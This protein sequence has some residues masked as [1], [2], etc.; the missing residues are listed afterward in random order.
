MASR[1]RP[2]ASRPSEPPAKQEAPQDAAERTVIT[3]IPVFEDEMPTPVPRVQTP[4]PRA[5]SPR[6]Q[7]TRSRPD[8]QRRGLNVTPARPRPPSK[9]GAAVP[10]ATRKPAEGNANSM[11][12]E[13]T[14][15]GLPVGLGAGPAPKPKA[16][17]PLPPAPK[18]SPQRSASPAVPSRGP[19]VPPLSLGR[20]AAVP[21]TPSPGLRLPKPG[22]MGSP[23]PAP[24]VGAAP[25]PPSLS[26]AL[27]QPAGLP[28]SAGNAGLPRPT[29]SVDDNSASSQRMM[30]AAGAVV[31]LTIGV[32]V[33]A[34]SDSE[35]EPAPGAPVV[36]SRTT[37]TPTANTN[38]VGRTT[39]AAGQTQP[40]SA[41]Q[42]ARRS[43]R[44]GASIARR[45]G[46]HPV[47]G[48]SRLAA[49]SKPGADVP[50]FGGAVRKEFDYHRS[51]LKDDD[52]PGVPML[53]I[54]TQPPGMTIEVAGQ[55]YGRT[56]LLKPLYTP[57]SSLD[58]R[59]TGA[60]FQDQRQTVRAAKDGSIRLNAI[61][62]SLAE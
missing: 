37:V 38:N 27:S 55:L 32:F 42:R 49:L 21:G 53:M 18:L 61:M 46:G 20:P 14:F 30:L 3:Q 10:V 17:L 56:P 62:T 22:G 4:P 9:L 24:A 50:E 7:V 15:I 35:P 13:A 60:G 57:V 23:V 40:S 34:A 12:R 41:V 11:P 36:I 43:K 44:K 28:L 58:I 1:R 47:W 16:S 59:L 26:G 19:A 2:P 52:G 51:Y 54:F 25:E 39:V 33:Y 6:G 31:A 8:A 45:R 29:S 48:K 5:P